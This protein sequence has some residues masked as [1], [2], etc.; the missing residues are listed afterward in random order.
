MLYACC[1]GLGSPGCTERSGRGIPSTLRWQTDSICLLCQRHRIS[2]KNWAPKHSAGPDEMRTEMDDWEV[3]G[4]FWPIGPASYLWAASAN[5][6]VVGHY[7][8]AKP[9]LQHFSA[10]TAR[11][12]TCQSPIT[13]LLHRSVRK[14]CRSES[15]LCDEISPRCWLVYDGINLIVLLRSEP[16]SICVPE[17]WINSLYEFEKS[18]GNQKIQAIS[19]GELPGFLVPKSWCPA[20]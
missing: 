11:G 16:C 9:S 19:D 15:E 5:R 12:Q 1:D 3:T 18:L 13:Q 14:A 8:S 6:L 7:S 10:A 2:W 4:F 17:R 20:V